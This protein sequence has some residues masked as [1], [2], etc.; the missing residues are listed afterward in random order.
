MLRVL[1]RRVHDLPRS[2]HLADKLRESNIRPV[3]R[4]PNVYIAQTHDEANALAE[5]FDQDRFVG[6]DTKLM[7]PITNVTTSPLPIGCSYPPAMLDKSTARHG[8]LRHYGLP[9]EAT[10]RPVSLIQI[11]SYHTCVLFQIRRIMLQPPFEFPAN[12]RRL[13]VDSSVTKFGVNT[14]RNMLQLRYSYNVWGAGGHDLRSIVRALGLT[15][16]SAAAAAD[17]R[18]DSVKTFDELSYLFNEHWD[19]RYTSS[20]SDVWDY[21]A[22]NISM[23]GVR[24]AADEALARY[25]VAY[26]LITLDMLPDMPL[27]RT[28]TPNK[29]EHRD[30]I[31]RL[32][33]QYAAMLPVQQGHRYPIVSVERLLHYLVNKYERWALLYPPAKRKTLLRRV[34]FDLVLEGRAQVFATDHPDS[35]EVNPS[36]LDEHVASKLYLGIRATAP[37]RADSRPSDAEPA[38]PPLPAQSAADDPLQP[39]D[40][41]RRQVIASYASSVSSRVREDLYRRFPQLHVSTS[42][43]SATTTLDALLAHMLRN[44]RDVAAFSPKR[45][46]QEELVDELMQQFDDNGWLYHDPLDYF[47]V[48]LISPIQTAASPVVARILSQS[49][50]DSIVSAVYKHLTTAFQHGQELQLSKLSTHM[51]LTTGLMSWIFDWYVRQKADEEPGGV[52]LSKYRRIRASISGVWDMDRVT[53]EILSTWVIDELV[54]RG[55]LVIDTDDPDKVVFLHVQSNLQ[56]SPEQLSLDQAGAQQQRSASALWHEQI[57]GIVAADYRQTPEAGTQDLRK[58][59]QTLR[60]SM[61]HLAEISLAKLLTLLNLSVGRS[62][63]TSFSRPGDDRHFTRAE[64]LRY[65]DGLV[66]HNALIPTLAQSVYYFNRHCDLHPDNVAAAPSSPPPFVP[67]PYTVPS[68][69]LL[70]RIQR[71]LTRAGGASLSPTQIRDTIDQW[72]RVYHHG[73]SRSDLVEWV[74]KLLEH[75]DQ[76]HS[77]TVLNVRPP[78]DSDRPDPPPTM[79][80]GGTKEVP[81]SLPPRRAVLF[82]NKYR[83]TKKSGPATR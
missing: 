39:G 16:P 32:I 62:S 47:Q 46:D 10:R 19:L 36:T 27:Q 65:V 12:L 83:E 52:T 7:K 58:I 73:R 35:C 77:A 5:V 79:T 54:H 14:P 31:M 78:D 24:Q 21:D 51:Y 60:G 68:R 43:P 34:I 2:L 49:V 37:K 59:Y 13:L 48:S 66:R 29:E 11:S 57:P 28:V 44:S 1:R 3:L 38:P 15:H 40:D 70:K 81:S 25:L 4:D 20:S 42:K 6:F 30:I 9:T 72:L 41:A 53:G 23:H 61:Q 74:V 50:P 18:V 64:R 63:L 22:P 17:S 67:P 45:A 69:M 56:E 33:K 26:K 76:L 8:D 55:I 75:F 71:D 80:I 82:P